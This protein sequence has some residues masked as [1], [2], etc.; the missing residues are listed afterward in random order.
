MCYFV[1][2]QFCSLAANTLRKESKDFAPTK[3]FNSLS[4]ASSLFEKL[5]NWG[6][7]LLPWILIMLENM[8]VSKIPYVGKVVG[9]LSNLI[10]F[11]YNIFSNYWVIIN[12]KTINSSSV[13]LSSSTF[14][15]YSYVE[16]NFP[17]F[18]GFAFP[19]VFPTFILIPNVY[20]STLLFTTASFFSIVCAWPSVDPKADSYKDSIKIGN[21]CF[22][23]FYFIYL[24]K[25]CF[26]VTQVNYTQRKD[27]FIIIHFHLFLVK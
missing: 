13:P 21:F 11:A 3:K 2:G 12:S 20:I 6:L 27:L 14:D 7:S 8:A 22:F 1:S 15:R 19:V 25:V 10:Y 5:I 9:L 16:M 26:I 24:L 18:M 4:D 23:I 17:Y